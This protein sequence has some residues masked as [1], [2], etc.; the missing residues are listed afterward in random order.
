[1]KIDN[2]GVNGFASCENLT[3]K[4]K[5]LSEMGRCLF[6]LLICHLAFFAAATIETLTAWRGSV[7]GGT[8]RDFIWDRFLRIGR[9]AGP[10]RRLRRR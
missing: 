2:D 9:A 3:I 8:W 6:E 1:L 5:L 4:A 7:A 10:S